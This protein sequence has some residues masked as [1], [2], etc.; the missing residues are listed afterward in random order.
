ML[1]KIVVV[2]ML[3][4]VGVAGSQ[5]FDLLPDPEAFETLQTAR[6]FRCSFEDMTDD[7][8]IDSVE[9]RDGSGTAR[10]VGNIGT[11][12]LMAVLGLD[13]TSFIEITP[14]GAVNVIHRLR[15]VG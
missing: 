5:E 7:T 10:L 4:S 2:A 9:Y 3:L 6:T 11:A 1:G 14:A 13:R 8:V 15:L 12:E